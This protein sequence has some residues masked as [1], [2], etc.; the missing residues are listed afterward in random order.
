MRRTFSR[1]FHAVAAA[2]PCPPIA[3]LANGAR[4]EILAPRALGKIVAVIPATLA[5]LNRWCGATHLPY[6]VAQHS[7][8]LA[9]EVRKRGDA[10]AALYALF[11]DAHEAVIGDVT[12]PC[13]SAIEAECPGVLDRIRSRIDAA[14]YPA[15]GL[16]FPVPPAT[17]A[18]IARVH[19]ELA[20]AEMRDLSQYFTAEIDDYARRGILPLRTAIRPQTWAKAEETFVKTQSALLAEAGMAR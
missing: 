12:R 10:L 20:A 4:V 18:L 8:I 17:A 14:L 6:S 7:E 19:D 1:G 16:D 3:V 9:R 11:H 13:E 5:R 2:E 15:L